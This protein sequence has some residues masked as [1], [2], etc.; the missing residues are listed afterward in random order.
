MIGVSLLRHIIKSSRKLF[1]WEFSQMS[2]EI[3]TWLMSF[4][5]FL[6]NIVIVDC[7]DTTLWSLSHEAILNVFICNILSTFSLNYS[8]LICKIPKCWTLKFIY[9]CIRKHYVWTT[10]KHCIL[11]PYEMINILYESISRDIDWSW[12]I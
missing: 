8:L 6:I 11:S 2:T 3:I 10:I 12:H 7:N 9:D 1:C 4:L 5:L